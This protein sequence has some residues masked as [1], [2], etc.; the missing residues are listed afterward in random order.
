MPDGNEGT[1]YI[2]FGSEQFYNA[3]VM[4]DGDIIECPH[5]G[6]EHAVAAAYAEG[7]EPPDGFHLFFFHC[8]DES[9]LAG[10]NGKS[11]MNIKPQM[12][13]RI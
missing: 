13:G 12:T 1:P 10:V 11:T 6:Q 2:G 5:C 7:Q 4:H 8:G 9:Y 3:P